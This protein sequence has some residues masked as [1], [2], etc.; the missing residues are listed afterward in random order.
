MRKEGNVSART[1]RHL[2]AARWQGLLR[3]QIDEKG[4]RKQFCQARAALPNVQR[5]PITANCFRDTLGGIK[6][7]THQKM[8]ISIQS[9]QT[10]N[11]HPPSWL[12][13]IRSVWLLMGT[14]TETSNR[15]EDLPGN[16]SSMTRRLKAWWPTKRWTSRRSKRCWAENDQ[17]RFR[18]Q[19]VLQTM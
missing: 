1:C 17:A 5:R 4:P 11:R 13:R 8:F 7:N 12:P 6:N 3:W 9:Y 10:L 19:A 16:G 2:G 14:Y 15:G 18:H